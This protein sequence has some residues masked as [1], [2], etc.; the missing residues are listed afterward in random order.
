[1]P[2]YLLPLDTVLDKLEPFEVVSI[3]NNVFQALENLHLV[4]YTH[5]DIKPDNIMMDT[6]AKATL[7]DLGCTTKFITSEKKHIEAPQT[8]IKFRGNILFSSV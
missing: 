6:D 7:I 4:G 8:N 2:K 1:M 5:N 3:M